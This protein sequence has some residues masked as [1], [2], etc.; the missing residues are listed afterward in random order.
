MT[1]A[2]FRMRNRNVFPPFQLIGAKEKAF[3]RREGSRLARGHARLR[4]R[5]FARALAHYVPEYSGAGVPSDQCATG[6]KKHVHGSGIL[7]C[8]SKTTGERRR[9]APQLAPAFALSSIGVKIITCG[10]HALAP[11]FK[12]CDFDIM[13]AIELGSGVG[14]AL[15]AIAATM[16]SW[17][18]DLLS[19]A[20]AI[21]VRLEV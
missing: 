4:R 5:P 8:A 2:N 21:S 10:Y 13:Y 15:A 17:I 7:S 11:S 16:R 20:R 3:F 19:P 18:C 9:S 14:S 1:A 12:Y 6:M